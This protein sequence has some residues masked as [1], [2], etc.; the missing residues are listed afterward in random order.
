M[1]IEAG[2]RPPA[3]PTPARPTPDRPTADP[4]AAPSPRF[5]FLS[6]LVHHR[7]HRHRSHK[8][9][10]SSLPLSL[11]S[12]PASVRLFAFTSSLFAAPLFSSVPRRRPYP[13]IA[14][15]PIPI[16][17]S[18]ILL[19]SL[20]RWLSPAAHSFPGP[21]SPP[22]LDR[23]SRIRSFVLP[24]RCRTAALSSD[25]TARL[26]AIISPSPA[27]VRISHHIARLCPPN[28]NRHARLL[29]PGKARPQART[30]PDEIG[31]PSQSHRCLKTAPSPIQHSPKMTA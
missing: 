7:H 10:H 25:S 11:Q 16:A 24:D 28:S 18:A 8:L 2:R 4:T 22:L 27:S 30:K 19:F 12:P 20:P 9:T 13:P 29:V 14:P 31:T 1:L 5:G 21:A 3:Q 26:P 23:G 6:F 15:L 17:P